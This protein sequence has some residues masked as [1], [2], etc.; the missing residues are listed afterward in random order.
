[1]FS[2]DCVHGTREQMMWMQVVLV[3]LSHGE[4]IA[5]DFFYA[6]LLLVLEINCK[7]SWDVFILFPDII[8]Y[9]F[10]FLF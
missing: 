9:G 1:V 3:E 7:H 2:D 5:R 6:L 8:I 10:F 4:G